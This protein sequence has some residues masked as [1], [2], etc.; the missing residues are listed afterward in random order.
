MNTLDHKV[1]FQKSISKSSNDLILGD[2]NKLQTSAS[3]TTAIGDLASDPVLDQQKNIVWAVSWRPDGRKLAVSTKNTIALYDFIHDSLEYAD[4]FSGPTGTTVTAIAWSGDCRQ[5]AFGSTVHD[6]KN[7]GGNGRAPVVIYEL[8]SDSNT[9]RGK[10]KFHHDQAIQCLAYQPNVTHNQPNRLV[11]C[12][13][14]DYSM[15]DSSTSQVHK[16]N[17][18]SKIVCLDWH[19]SGENIKS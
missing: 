18:E 17:V 3:N 19:S 13:V 9:Y 12:S 15:W 16:A 8:N 10:L 5:L 2:L 4:Q 6:E 7:S 1:V 14:E 11:T